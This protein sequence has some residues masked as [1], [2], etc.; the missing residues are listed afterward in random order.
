MPVYLLDINLAFLSKGTFFSSRIP[1]GVNSELMQHPSEL[2]FK[3]TVSFF[4]T[5]KAP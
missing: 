2:P 5:T 4:Q 3:W 1:P